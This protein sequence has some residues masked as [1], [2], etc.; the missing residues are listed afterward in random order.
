MD[1][2]GFRAY[3]ETRQASE[4]LIERSIALAGRF[5][6]Y[7]REVHGA[8]PERASADAARSFARALMQTGE[9]S[10]DNLLAV[11][12]FGRFLGNHEVVVAILD[13]VDGHE[14][15]GN[16]ARKV[17]E[18]A[19]V[20]ARDE[21]FAGIDLPPL[22]VPNLDRARRMRTVVERLEDLFGR[23][24]TERLIGQG[25][26]DL[27]GPAFAGEKEGYEKAGGIDEYLR[28]KGDR[29]I[30]EL[31]SLRD[32]G[33][34][35]FTQPITDAVI[36]YVESHPEIRQGV[37][38]GNILYEAKIPYLADAYVAEKDPRK[39]AYLYC[40]CPWARELLQ[41]DESPV[42]ASFCACSGAFHRRP[43]EVIFGRPLQ[44]EVLE[45]VL[46]GDPWCRF[47][48]VLPEDVA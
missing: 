48:I 5:E 9:N 30:A 7:A 1:K 45:T 36:A 19:G 15:L 28:R 37:R 44:S 2:T 27:P 43:Y 47:A 29:F 41:T 6:T 11:G 46:A 22:G 39:R 14:A 34:L 4:G 38:V 16:L 40:H 20:R 12:R 13:I 26:R 32:S 35:Y 33:A 18:E 23:D 42:P 21:V 17:E 3:L 31:T 24:R 25:L 10:F 8:E